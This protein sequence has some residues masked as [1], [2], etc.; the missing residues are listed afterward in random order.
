MYNPYSPEYTHTCTY[1]R[2]HTHTHT[3]TRIHKQAHTRTHTHT[4]AHARAHTH[5]H[6]RA[7]SDNNIYSIFE[8][9]GSKVIKSGLGDTYPTEIEGRSTV[10]NW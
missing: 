7:A 1:I 10:H 2:T 4:R 9:F 3:H 8:S 5:T 6:T